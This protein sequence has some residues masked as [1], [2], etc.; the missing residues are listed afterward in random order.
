MNLRAMYAWMQARIETKMPCGIADVP[1]TNGNGN[2][3]PY[4]VVQGITA[5]ADELW[6]ASNAMHDEIV[7]VSAIGATADQALWAQETI[8]HLLQDHP[9]F[10]TP[11][12]GCTLDSG[13]ALIREDDVTYRTSDT[14]RTKVSL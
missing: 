6:F 5:A 13:G 1:A 2:G 10:T 8:R 9:T 11:V 7:Q 3:K 12:V 4:A 14:F